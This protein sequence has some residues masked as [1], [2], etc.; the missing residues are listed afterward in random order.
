LREKNLAKNEGKAYNIE[1]KTSHFTKKA[2]AGW[3]RKKAKP[4]GSTGVQLKASE[5][6][7]QDTLPGIEGKIAHQGIQILKKGLA[8]SQSLADSPVFLVY[9]V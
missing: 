8:F 4:F 3:L 9:Q 2:E 1:A 5:H 7:R 6:K